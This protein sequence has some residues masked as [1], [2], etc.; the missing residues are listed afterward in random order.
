M[1]ASLQGPDGK[2]VALH[3]TWLVPEGR[4]IVPNLSVRE[5]LDLGAYRRARGNR[6]RSPRT[7]LDFFMWPLLA[8]PC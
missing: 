8:T 6:A 3:R 2:V 7:R 4:K 1:V 5:N